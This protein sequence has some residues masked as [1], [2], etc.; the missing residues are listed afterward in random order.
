MVY[1]W[2]PEKKML[3]AGL[4]VDRRNV[5]FVYTIFKVGDDQVSISAF[6]FTAPQFSGLDKGQG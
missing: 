1:N 5:L 4:T 2:T 6:S 3:K